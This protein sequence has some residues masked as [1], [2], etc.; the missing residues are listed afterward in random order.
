MVKITIFN[1]IIDALTSLFASITDGVCTCSIA[2]HV[3]PNCTGLFLHLTR[4]V[5]SGTMAVYPDSGGTA[6]QI[7]TSGTPQ[8]TVSFFLPISGQ[9]IKYSASA[10]AETWTWK[11]T[12]YLI[13]GERKTA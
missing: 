1:E 13:E 4:G 11:M 12:G 9:A 3:P 2:A 7:Q 5:G 10:D 6:I 8:C